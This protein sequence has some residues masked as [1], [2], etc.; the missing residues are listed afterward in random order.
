MSSTL[1]LAEPIFAPIV[2]FTLAWVWLDLHGCGKK[3]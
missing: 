2:S 3:T 1:L